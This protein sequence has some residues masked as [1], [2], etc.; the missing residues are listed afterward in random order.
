MRIYPNFKASLDRCPECD[1]E[2]ENLVTCRSC[3]YHAGAELAQQWIDY[4]ES[5]PEVP[6]GT[7][8]TQAHEG[9]PADYYFDVKLDREKSDPAELVIWLARISPSGGTTADIEAAD[10]APLLADGKWLSADE[11]KLID[12]LAEILDQEGWGGRETAVPPSE[13]LNVVH[14]RIAWLRDMRAESLR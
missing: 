11:E 3:D 1:F 8:I 4:V 14:E 9:E 7:V 13:I 6:V 5:L 10:V 2:Q 12:P